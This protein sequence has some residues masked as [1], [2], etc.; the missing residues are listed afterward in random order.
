MRKA[1][2]FVEVLESFP[3]APRGVLPLL[4]AGGP[5]RFVH[6]GFYSQDNEAGV[7][8]SQNEDVRV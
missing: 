5:K 4:A 2:N 1:E 7:I 6:L 3:L 8:A